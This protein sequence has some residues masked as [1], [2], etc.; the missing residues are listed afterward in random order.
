MSGCVGRTEIGHAE[1]T[2][3]LR[4]VSIGSSRL[5]SSLVSSQGREVSPASARDSEGPH[6]KSDS[7]LPTL[8]G[9]R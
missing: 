6:A 4:V 1:Y 9:V 7:D 8:G 2:L 5:A 3:I